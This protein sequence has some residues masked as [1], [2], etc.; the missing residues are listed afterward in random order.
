MMKI[1]DSTAAGN[2]SV[3]LLLLL[4][5]QDDVKAARKIQLEHQTLVVLQYQCHRLPSLLLL[6]LPKQLL[7][8][9]II[10]QH[11]RLLHVLLRLLLDGRCRN[12]KKHERPRPLRSLQVVLLLLLLDG[13]FRNCN[14]CQRP[15]RPLPLYV[16][17]LLLLD[18]RKNGNENRHPCDRR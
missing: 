7:L 13:H 14:K 16:V 2:V 5:L 9:N 4:L 8:L 12:G 15:L 11:L 17:L 6:L 18:R 1:K 10:D 3:F